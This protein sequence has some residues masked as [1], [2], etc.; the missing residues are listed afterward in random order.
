MEDALAAPS[1]AEAGRRDP[2]AEHTEGTLERAIDAPQRVGSRL[3]TLRTARTLSVRTLA[4]R[5]GFS[6]SFVSQVENGQASPS[7]ASL[8]RLV[9]ALG[10]TLREFFT[11]DAP[12]ATVRRA[13][14]RAALESDWS[15]ARLESLAG[16][17]FE[18]LDAVLLTM[19][20]SGRSGRELHSLAA[21]LFAFVVEGSITL[22][23]GEEA[24]ILTRGD[25]VTLSSG[26]LHRWSNT[27][28]TTAQVLLIS[29]DSRIPSGA[30]DS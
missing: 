21:P 26:S 14:G 19:R 22:E 13:S 6:A 4:T 2:V 25:T 27:S 20:S 30:T 9:G 16:P 8:E 7:I 24:T 17:A 29:G 11:E 28:P 15:K 3:R 1:G 12:S 23:F 5:A 10:L 18:G